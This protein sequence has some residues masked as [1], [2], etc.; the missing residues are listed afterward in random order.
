MAHG[1]YIYG[2]GKADLQLPRVSGIGDGV[3]RPVAHNDLVAVV[4][5]LDLAGKLRPQRRHL[6]AHQA[7]LRTVGEQ[8]TV[9]P[10]AFGVVADDE[11]DVVELLADNAETLGGELDRVDGCVEMGVKLR[12]VVDNV[13]EHFVDEYP[14]LRDRRD[15]LVRLGE[16]A[17]HDL[18]VQTGRLFRTILDDERRA[19]E[20]VVLDHVEPICR[21]IDRQE[22]SEETVAVAVSCLVER[23]LLGE[24]ESAIERAA[25]EYD[26]RF[27]FELSGPWA[28]HS[29]VRLDLELNQTASEVA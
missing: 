20:S 21:E 15:E 26:D 1:I 14:E 9:L 17:P 10:M 22:P 18:R 19:H 23:S 2:I 13:F 11:A 8:G 6:A 7:V 4:S 3:V 24:F 12:W 25:R 5:E 27:G 16:A 29:F 28:P